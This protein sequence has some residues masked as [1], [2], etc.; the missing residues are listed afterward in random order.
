M[1]GA[2][3]PLSIEITVKKFVYIALDKQIILPFLPD[4][5]SI[6][7]GLTGSKQIIKY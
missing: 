7:N 3:A 1:V 2:S 6:S 4:A 5:L